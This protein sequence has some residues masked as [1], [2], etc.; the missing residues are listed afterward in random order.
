MA[1][2]ALKAPEGFLFGCDPELFI[3]NDKNEP[4][5]AD[6][7]I[8]GTKNNPYQVKDGAV[9]VDGFAAEFNIEP[10]SN[11]KEFTFKIDS[12]LGQMQKMLPS[13]YSLK[14]VPHVEF[15][16][17]VWEEAPP[18]AK[19][20]GCTPDFNA[21]TGMLNPPPQRSENSRMA[22]AGGHI[23]TGWTDEADLGDMQHIMNCRDL[24]KQYDWILGL[25]SI[26]KD[27]DPV[28]RT[29]YGKAGACRY[30]EYGVEYR[31]LSNF[32]V[33]DKNTRFMMWNRMVAAI[34]NMNSNFFPDKYFKWNS[35]VQMSLDTS[36]LD[37]NMIT[38]FRFPIE[39]LSAL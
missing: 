9:Q 4:V 28:R 25:W 16:E 5:C 15:S 22:C 11:Y 24:V 35:T 14:A 38:R 21:W 32:W 30:K 33:L 1:K 29:L 27:P 26:L 10:V 39:R 13:G 8:P 3:F 37:S 7:L 17:K 18:E 36:Q 19:E 6:G 34:H 2:E 20:L 31:A 12:V 23:H